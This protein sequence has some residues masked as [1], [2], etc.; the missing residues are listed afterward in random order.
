MPADAVLLAASVDREA[1]KP[2]R[3][4][5]VDQRL[6]ATALAHMRRIPRH[7]LAACPVH[8]TEHGAGTV[9]R[10]VWVC[11]RQRHSV[12]GPVIGAP[13]WLPSSGSAAANA[14]SISSGLR[15]KAPRV[16]S[17]RRPAPRRSCTRKWGRCLLLAL[18]RCP[19]HT[20]S[21]RLQGEPDGPARRPW[22][23][24]FGC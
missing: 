19:H 23:R 14:A 21:P 22:C 24:A 5:G 15:Q 2:A 12:R 11:L 8:V 9:R 16:K 3:A 1:I 18:V 10:Y 20:N 4:T 17:P 6:L 7:V 13:S